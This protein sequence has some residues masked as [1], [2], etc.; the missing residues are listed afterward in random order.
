MVKSKTQTYFLLIV[1]LM[2]CGSSLTVVTEKKVKY[3]A[4]YG[5]FLYRVTLTHALQWFGGWTHRSV[6]GYIYRVRRDI[7]DYKTY[8]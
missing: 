2:P 1:N 6:T 8:R 3:M 7:K 4:M 5:Q